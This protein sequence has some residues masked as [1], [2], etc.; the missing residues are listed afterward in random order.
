MSVDILPG[1]GRKG[2]PSS[3]FITP[4]SPEAAPAGWHNLQATA[5]PVT[6]AY[7]TAQKALFFPIRLFRSETV[8]R[9]FWVNGTTAS[10]DDIAVG[11]YDMAGHSIALGTSS[12]ANHGTLATGTSQCQFD[13]ITDFVLGPGE[14][15]LAI[16]SSGGTTHLLRT[17]VNFRQLAESGAYQQASLTTGLPTTATLA[18]ITAAYLPLFGLSLRS[19]P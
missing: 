16:W 4:Y 3:V 7:P 8:K 19:T 11:V 14:F 12:G 13:N 9:F 15:L 18:S 2:R 6:A 5:N 17:A 10:T 1:A